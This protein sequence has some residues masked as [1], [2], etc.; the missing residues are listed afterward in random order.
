[1]EDTEAIPKTE[2]FRF[3]A[4]RLWKELV[5]FQSQPCFLSTVPAQ[6]QHLGW[7]Q[8]FSGQH[9]VGLTQRLKQSLWLQDLS[10]FTS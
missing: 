10:E 2:I 4:I 5:S 3:K 8:V 9:F 1:M 6:L 7:M